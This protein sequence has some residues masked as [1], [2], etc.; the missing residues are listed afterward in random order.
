M[1]TNFFCII[2]TVANMATIVTMLETKSVGYFLPIHTFPG[3][4]LL[5]M[6][7]GTMPHNLTMI[8]TWLL[9]KPLEILTSAILTMF[10][11][12]SFGEDCVHYQ[13]N[14]KIKWYT[15]DSIHQRKDPDAWWLRLQHHADVFRIS[16]AEQV[17]G[18]ISEQFVTFWHHRLFEC[19]IYF[20]RYE[21][22]QYGTAKD[23]MKKCRSFTLAFILK[24]FYIGTLKHEAAE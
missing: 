4:Y 24:Q 11:S 19:H 22:E 17:M 3:E 21:N 1:R 6:R 15:Q 18:H 2:I 14:F 13:C 12:W 9:Q 7:T 16:S 5:E 20:D 8:N 10:R 23:S